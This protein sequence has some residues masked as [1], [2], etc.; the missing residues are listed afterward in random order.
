V[1]I[2]VNAGSNEKAIPSI[3][4]TQVKKE[5]VSRVKELVNELKSLGYT[6]KIEKVVSMEF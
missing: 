1:S 3:A 4:V 6:G 5:V 2:I